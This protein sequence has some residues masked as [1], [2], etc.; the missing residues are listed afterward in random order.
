MTLCEDV[1]GLAECSLPLE[2]RYLA[3]EEIPA[4][5]VCYTV[6]LPNHA[7]YLYAARELLS[8][9][10]F[11]EVWDTNENTIEDWE[12]AG[13]GG[14]IAIEVCEEA[15][16]P[17]SIPISGTILW[18][19]P[20][21][22]DGFIECDG[23]L[24][25]IATYPELFA[26][27]G[28][29]FGGADDWFQLPEPSGRMIVGA[30]ASP[31]NSVGNTGGSETHTLTIAEMP[32]HTHN[33]VFSASTGPNAR[34]AAGGAFSSNQPTGSAGG[35]GAHNNMPPYIVGRWIIRAY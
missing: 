35:G 9:L 19:N 21:L 20:A 27:L 17:M 3:P 6:I 28:Y 26:L 4:E 25:N 2:N 16:P 12:A 5:T 29:Y 11:L 15:E 13:L 24:H 10:A 30:G 23:S 1:A 33:L 8:R 14:E 7:Q 18:W 22:P 34:I 31:F 32:A